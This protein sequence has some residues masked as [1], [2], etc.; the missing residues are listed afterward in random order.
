MQISLADIAPEIARQIIESPRFLEASETSGTAVRGRRFAVAMKTLGGLVGVEAGALLLRQTVSDLGISFQNDTAAIAATAVWLA[1]ICGAPVA[2]AFLYLRR[3]GP[4]PL[5]VEEKRTVPFGAA[6]WRALAGFAN[7][8]GA[9][10]SYTEA[11][12]SLLEAADAGRLEEPQARSLLSELNGLAESDR[13]LLGQ[14]QDLARLTTAEDVRRLTKERESLSARRDAAGDPATRSALE[15]SLA[16]LDERIAHASELSPLL[17]R[18]GAQREVVAQ[19]LASLGAAL[20]R[21]KVAPQVA[22]SS[23]PAAEAE[24]AGDA[25]RGIVQQTRAVEQAV[26]EVVALRAGGG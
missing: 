20:L 15:Q 13:A 1:T 9:Q 22:D 2:A 7:F 21:L 3:A 8:T 26:A 11:V 14:Q 17:E 18:V 10:K 16:L 24:R 12:T 19:T 25:A 23:A 5:R 4:R 6:G